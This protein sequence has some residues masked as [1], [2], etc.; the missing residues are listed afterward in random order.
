V[1]FAHALVHGLA[2]HGLMAR[3][4]GWQLIGDLIDLRTGGTLDESDSALWRRWIAADVTDLEV[5]AALD[6]GRSVAAGADPL[7]A[8]SDPLA[9]RLAQHILACALDSDYG[10][11]LKSRWLE[12]PVSDRPLASARL[13]LLA[14]AFVPSWPGADAGR[15]TLARE[16]LRWG[17]RPFDLAARWL[18]S[19]SA[20]RRLRRN[21]K[22]ND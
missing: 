13:R 5:D 6:L 1:R 10:A 9:R 7:D 4:P 15:Q 16:A 11:S 12:S 20:A 14:R 2:Q 17:A 3:T 19:R 18:S 8:A 22:E 21:L